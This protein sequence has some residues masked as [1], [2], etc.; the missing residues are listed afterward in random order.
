VYFDLFPDTTRYPEEW[1]K[2]FALFFT[3]AELVK[4]R[5]II[6]SMWKMIAGGQSAGFLQDMLR[7]IDPAIQVIENIPTIDPRSSHVVYINVCNYQFMRCG[8]NFAR[9]G[10]R[11]GDENFVPTV[12]R[13]DTS[14]LYELPDDPRFWQF[15][16]FV[17][18][19][20]VRDSS[21]RIQH[22]EPIKINKIWKNYIEYIILKIKPVHS[23]AVVFIK[24][25]EGE[26]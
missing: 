23:T 26:P 15:C 25:T 12:L 11:I 21:Q 14:T 6:D 22:V 3:E 24:W 1:E 10:M 18:K 2:V 9:C 17:C 19:G 20:V 8:H 5:E 7:R 16:F 13:N 4:R